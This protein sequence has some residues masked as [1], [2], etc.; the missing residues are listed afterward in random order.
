ME[1]GCLGFGGNE[2]LEETDHLLDLGQRLLTLER[3]PILEHLGGDDGVG[4]GE[5]AADVEANDAV[6]RSAGGR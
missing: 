4:V 6:L 5:V 2:L 1:D 3:G